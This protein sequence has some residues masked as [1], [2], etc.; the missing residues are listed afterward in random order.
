[1]GE[2]LT[3]GARRGAGQGCSSLR[4]QTAMA[5]RQEPQRKSEAGD[6]SQSTRFLQASGGIKRTARRGLCPRGPWE[7]R[8]GGEE[9]NTKRCSLPPRGNTEEQIISLWFF[10]KIKEGPLAASGKY[11][12]NP[13]VQQF[14][15][16][17]ALPA[18]QVSR[19][20]AGER[21]AAGAGEV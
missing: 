19:A 14:L 13:F 1:M 4:A 2:G 6:V 10:C 16:R 20:V 21:P 9:R 12:P 7:T 5:L 18:P 17:R 11:F 15:C 8:S 3:S